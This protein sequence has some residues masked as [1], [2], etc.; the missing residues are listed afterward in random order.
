[1]LRA[2]GFGDRGRLRRSLVM[3]SP[4]VGCELEEVV[5]GA[6]HGP[7]LSD[8][9][10]AAE[11]ELAEASCGFDLT[12]DRLDDLLSQSVSTASRSLSQA[13]PHTLNPTSHFSVLPV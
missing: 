4:G 1:M 2:G 5:G 9:F 8:L 10:E 7:F 6:D 12:E 11:E 3:T 13:L